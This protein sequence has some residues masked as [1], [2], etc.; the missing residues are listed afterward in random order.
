M[1]K[2]SACPHLE[3][4]SHSWLAVRHW[5]LWE[6]T[7]PV[8]HRLWGH[9]LEVQSRLCHLLAA[10]I[11]QDASEAGSGPS[12]SVKDD[13]DPTGI[14]RMEGGEICKTHVTNAY[15]DSEQGR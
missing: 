9:T 2:L 15:Q 13:D 6:G 3:F 1:L 4:G 14:W 10:D 5:G 8:Q 11:G 7:W 12:S